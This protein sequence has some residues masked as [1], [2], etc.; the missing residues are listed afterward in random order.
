MHPFLLIYIEYFTF[1]TYLRY[2]EIIQFVR[3]KMDQLSS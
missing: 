1:P 2:I 3:G